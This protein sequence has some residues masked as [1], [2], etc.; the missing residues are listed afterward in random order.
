MIAFT[1]MDHDVL[2]ANDF[3]GEAFLPLANIPGVTGSCATVGNFHGLK[4]IELPL[5][6][7]NSRRTYSIRMFSIRSQTFR[8][9]NENFALV[10]ILV[11]IDLPILQVLEK[12][13]GDRL[14][15]EFTRKQRL[16]FEDETKKPKKT[17]AQL[18]NKPR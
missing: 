16:R 9:P 3:G 1:L 18:P 14:A 17:K 10:L 8:S 12:R 6:Q 15:V 5:M 7:L 13:M 2:T 11:H 4:Q